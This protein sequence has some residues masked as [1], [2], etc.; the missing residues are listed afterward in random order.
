MSNQVPVYNGPAVDTDPTLCVCGHPKASHQIHDRFDER[1]W[2]ADCSF[3]KH[4]HVFREHKR[5]SK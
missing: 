3:H 2:C 1:L 4:L 5:D